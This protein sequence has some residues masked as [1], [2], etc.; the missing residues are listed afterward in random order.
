[1]NVCVTGGSGFI[2]SHLVHRLVQDGH[3]VTVIDNLSTGFPTHLEPVR[4]AIRFVQADIADPAGLPD[5]L[6]GCTVVLH[7]AALGSVPRS[8]DNPAATHAANVT[9]TLNL[10]QAAR[11]A[12]VRRVVAAGSSSVYGA[13]PVL[14]RHESLLPEPVSPYAASK[15]AAEAYCRAFEAVYGLETVVL[16]YFNVFGPRQNP[17]SQ[18]AAVIP[19][20]VSRMI[21]G[22]RPQVYGDGEQ[23]RDFTYVANVV[24]ANLR[25]MEAAPGCGGIYNVACG[26]QYTLNELV[27][28]INGV[29]G[30]ALEPEYLP[31]R[32]GD[33]RHSLADIGQAGAVLGYKPSVGFHEGIRRTVEWYRSRKGAPT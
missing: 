23:S 3:T 10:L 7:Q 19:R 15:L 26:G 20:F 6:Q 33:T 12:G 22:E 17:D 28:A 29:L 21:R 1:M 16:R 31:P 4:A 9:G 24:E 30:T 14:P 11:A 8:I 25:A 32:P 18:Y 27:S 5:A 13:N 2:G